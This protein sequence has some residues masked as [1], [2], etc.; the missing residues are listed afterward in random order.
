MKKS[1]LV[2]VVAMMVFTGI[3]TAQGARNLP[4]RPMLT[5]PVADL[6]NA[7]VVAINKQDKAF[8]DK[9]VAS[10]ATWADEDVHIFPAAFFINK[11]MQGIPRKLTIT[12]VAGETWDTGAW[13]AYD[14]TLDE[15]RAD[16]TQNQMKGTQSM[17]FRKIGNDW[18]V[19]FF[20]NAVDPGG[21]TH[22]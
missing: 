14:Y 13:A 16:G 6:L 9:V 21:V 2:C 19:V 10:N 22:R 18:Q 8:I 1:I 17:T 4:P 20:H 7:I 12:N 15:T 11:L 3:V 5:G